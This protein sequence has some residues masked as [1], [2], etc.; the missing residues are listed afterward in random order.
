VWGSV[1]CRTS[2]EY[3]CVC[4]DIGCF[5]DGPVVIVNEWVISIMWMADWFMGIVATDSVV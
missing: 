1:L 2:A 5:L 4:S 3:V